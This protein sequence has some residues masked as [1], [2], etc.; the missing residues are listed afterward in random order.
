MK[1][2]ILQLSIEANYYGLTGLLD[3]IAPKY[4]TFPVNQESKGIFFALGQTPLLANLLRDDYSALPYTN[5]TLSGHVIV[6]SSPSAESNAH[7]IDFNASSLQGWCND[8]GLGKQYF[9]VALKLFIARV[10]HF[11]LRY[12]GACC[13]PQHFQLLG[14]YYRYL[15]HDFCLL[16]YMSSFFDVFLFA[17]ELTFNDWYLG[18]MSGK[19]SSFI[20]I[21]FHDSPNP[22]NAGNPAVFKV[23]ESDTFFKYF[24]VKCTGHDSSGYGCFCFHVESL[25][26]FGEV[27]EI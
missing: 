14:M 4:K 20:A 12:T 24:Q 5:P 6:S 16:L 1:N 27:V 10:F 19:K 7:L 17:S 22:F 8:D 15:P 3:I 26:L 21:Y 2:D 13:Q 11:S 25:E 9:T 23:Q 18:S